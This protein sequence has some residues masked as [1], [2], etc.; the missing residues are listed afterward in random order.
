MQWKRRREEEEK[1]TA[2]DRKELPLLSAAPR[3]KPVLYWLTQLNCGVYEHEVGEQVLG[4]GVAVILPAR[5]SSSK[6][7][8]QQG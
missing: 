2:T 7:F 4:G 1:Y 3:R 6:P 8:Y 5:P